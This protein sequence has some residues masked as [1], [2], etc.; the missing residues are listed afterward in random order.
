MNMVGETYARVQKDF[1]FLFFVIITTNLSLSIYSITVQ[2][3]LE[4][5][6][7]F[8]LTIDKLL[9]NRAFFITISLIKLK[10]LI[11]KFLCVFVI[12]ILI[13]RN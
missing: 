7:L 10:T 4:C 12:I 5:G 3:T 11:T 2:R 9:S 8:T 13:Q 1:W 6:E